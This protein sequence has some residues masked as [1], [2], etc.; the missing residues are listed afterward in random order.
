MNILKDVF[1]GII[2][3][4]GHLLVILVTVL[5]YTFAGLVAFFVVGTVLLV[6]VTMFVVAFLLCVQIWAHLLGGF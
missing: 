2:V 6:I 1:K 4:L 5:A 3:F